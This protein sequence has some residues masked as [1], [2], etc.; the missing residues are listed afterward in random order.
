MSFQKDGQ[1]NLLIGGRRSSKDK[2]GVWIEDGVVLILC[3]S[4]TRFDGIEST[5]LYDSSKVF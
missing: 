5:T 2:S 3:D 4:A 1:L